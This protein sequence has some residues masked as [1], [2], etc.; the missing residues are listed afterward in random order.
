M[1]LQITEITKAVEE[2][3]MAPQSKILLYAIM[4]A[5]GAMA[6]VIIYFERRRVKKEEMDREDRLAHDKEQAAIEALLNVEKK[7]FAD[8]IRLDVRDIK[9]TQKDFIEKVTE[10]RIEH[11][12]KLNNH[13]SKLNN[14]ESRL[15]GHD[16]KIA[17]IK[18]KLEKK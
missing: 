6:T 12:S 3:G 9:Q 13:E 17:D 15:D 11:G 2:S 10:I 14:H 16:R 8:D 7:K 18:I 1:L 5:F 4:I